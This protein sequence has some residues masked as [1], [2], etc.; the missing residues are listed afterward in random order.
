MDHGLYLM[1]RIAI[2]TL[3]CKVNQFESDCLRERFTRQGWTPV[4]FAEEAEIY[5]VNT[6]AVTAEAQ[7]QSAQQVRSALR[8]QPEARVM[9]VGC[10]TQVYPDYFQKIAGLV[11]QTG[12]FDKLET[13]TR[14]VLGE[15]LEPAKA[16]L[17]GSSSPDRLPLE[18]PVSTRRSRALFRIQEGCDSSCSYCLVPQPG[19]VRE[20][21]PRKRSWKASN[22]WPAG[23]FRKSS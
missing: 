13:V 16:V 19:A 15:E 9:A 18:C 3:G 23:D 11:Y 1:K 22:G 12:T 10:A 7:R 5:L 17:P 14:W 4:A 20:A 21:F 2:H 6:C 8:R